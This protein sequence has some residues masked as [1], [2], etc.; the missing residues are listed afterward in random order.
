MKK[1]CLYVLMALLVPVFAKSVLAETF[2]W[3][4]KK[5]VQ[6]SNDVSKLPPKFRAKYEKFMKQSP[7][8]DSKT[9]IETAT[10]AIRALKKLESRTEAGISLHDYP[11][12]LGEV[13]FTVKMYLESK[14]AKGNQKATEDIKIVLEC[15][16][17]ALQYWSFA[18]TYGQSK[19]PT[20]STY[21]R[22]FMPVLAKVYPG[23]EKSTSEGGLV[24]E[25][26]YESHKFRNIYFS[27]IASYYWGKASV[28]LK[29]MTL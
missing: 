5:G 25:S 2:F 29:N 21:G 11:A 15:Y 7:V 14:A 12:A 24:V 13:K 20:D 27:D 3:E 1:T 9:G 28:I 22:E 17:K 8:Q 26:S 23:A 10:D 18:Q 19:L 16:E 6:M 4:D